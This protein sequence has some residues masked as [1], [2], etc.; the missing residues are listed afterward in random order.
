ME[1]HFLS[2]GKG[3]GGGGR[4]GGHLSHCRPHH[5]AA[6]RRTDGRTEGTESIIGVV[7]D[8]ACAS[9]PPSA[10]ALGLQMQ[11]S[12]VRLGCP[13][14]RGVRAGGAAGDKKGDGLSTDDVMGVSLNLS[15]ALSSLVDYK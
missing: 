15:L 11:D 2:K 13:R 4:G 5:V 1:C 8:A 12:S 3:G 14:K 10:S 9:L 6:T 7:T